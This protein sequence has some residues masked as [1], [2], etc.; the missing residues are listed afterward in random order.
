MGNN[1]NVL[2]I[3]AAHR[4]LSISMN[5]GKE[6]KSVWV[7]IPEDIVK[8][9][10]II[11]KSLF[12]SFLKETLKEHGFKAKKAAFVIGSD[13]VF[14]RNVKMPMMNDEQLRYNLPFEFRDSINGELKDY[15]Y[16]YAYRPSETPEEG[17]DAKTAELLAVAI[18]KEYYNSIS[19]IVQMAGI[20]LIKAVPEVCVLESYLKKLET[21]ED[22][23]AER[24]FLDIGHTGVRFQIFKNGRFKLAQLIDIGEDHIVRAIADDMNVDFELAQTYVR[25]Q[26]EDCG[27]REAAV[28]AYK[29]IS[30]EV[31]KGFNYYEMSDMSSRLN[32]VV[33]YGSGAMIDPLANMLKERIDKHVVTMNE[34]FPQYNKDNMLNIT[35]ASIGVNFDN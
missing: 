23:N 7:D 18:P 26:Y 25:T 27:S 9:G 19:E 12:T 5:N 1:D 28:N 21:E 10:E 6:I 8:R 32:E 13:Q 14:I 2:G 24:C 29:D 22:R 33:L 31:L 35:A 15:L 17:A 30:V 11:S 16:D 20:K 4:R 34:L 3:Y